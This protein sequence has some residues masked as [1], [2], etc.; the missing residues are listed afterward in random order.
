MSLREVAVGTLLFRPGRGCSL[1]SIKFLFRNKLLTGTTT[2]LLLLLTL[3]AA[4][5]DTPH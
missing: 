4:H 2:P 5:D 1:A 3:L